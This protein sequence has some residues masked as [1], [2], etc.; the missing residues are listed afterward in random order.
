MADPEV[1]AEGANIT[2]FR[3]M[4]GS[5]VP[6][7][8]PEHQWG[9]AWG[10]TGGLELYPHKNFQKINVEIAYFCI[11]ASRNDLVFPNLYLHAAADVQIARC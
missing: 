10:G 5:K 7:E 8:A 9:G 3:M 2:C 4:E 1:L 11:F 6:R